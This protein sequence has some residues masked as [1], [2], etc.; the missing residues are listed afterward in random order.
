ML[1]IRANGNADVNSFIQVMTNG[2]SDYLSHEVNIVMAIVSWIN[3]HGYPVVEIK[4]D[5]KTGS[6][7]ISQVNL[8]IYFSFLLKTKKK[9]K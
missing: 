9:R 4:R 6:A 1:F 8:I 5:Y 3:G 7:K 2:S